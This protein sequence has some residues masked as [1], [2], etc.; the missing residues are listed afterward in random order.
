MVKKK[1]YLINFMKTKYLTL[2]LLVF[3]ACSTKKKLTSND[4]QSLVDERDGHIYKTVKIGS[5]VWMAE[6]LN[7][8]VH[9][10]ESLVR[11]QPYNHSV[12]NGKIY[13]MLY[14]FRALDGAAPKGWHVP[15]IDEWRLME[16]ECPDPIK[17]LNILYGGEGR[18]STFT[19]LGEK[20]TFYTVSHEGTPIITIYVDKGSNTISENKQGIAWMLSVRCVKDPEPSK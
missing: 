4:V 10:N 1:L 11:C 5:Q 14:S 16:R 9:D 13:G 18:A 7:Y 6:N 19:K 15:S 17:T 20:A 8:A 12:D 3:A 2:L